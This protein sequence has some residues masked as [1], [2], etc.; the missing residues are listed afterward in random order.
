MS[1]ELIRLENVSYSYEKNKA[2]DHIDL[3]FEKKCYCIQGPNGCGKS[4]LFRILTGLSFPTEGHYYFKGNEINQ[5]YLRSDENRMK[6]HKAIGFVFQEPEV[7]LF[8]RS[9]EDEIAFGLF[10]LEKDPSEIRAKVD[11]YIK[12]LDLESVRERAPFNLSGG[13]KKRVAL[14]AILAMDSEILIMDEP[15]NGLDEEGQEFVTDLLIKL[16][17]T[18]RMII[19]SSHNSAFAKKIADTRIIMNKDHKISEIL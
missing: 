9:V 15:L 11:K 10:Q 1:E 19:L 4:S 18:G 6:F 12:M 13:E 7:Q 8:T 14:A 3:S 2:L 16:K 17:S 5:K